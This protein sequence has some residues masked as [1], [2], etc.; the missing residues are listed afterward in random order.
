[1]PHLM[2]SEDASFDA[3]GK[4]LEEVKC[5]TEGG[6]EV[7]MNES[8]KIIIKKESIIDKIV[9]VENDKIKMKGK[10]MV[11]EEINSGRI[12]NKIYKT[13]IEYSG[14]YIQVFL[15]FIFAIIWQFT[16]IQ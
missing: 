1:M 11:E 2:Q 3:S 15:V 14:G 5:K 6:E 9:E 13:I 4:S 16:I 8:D 10:L 12:G 7:E